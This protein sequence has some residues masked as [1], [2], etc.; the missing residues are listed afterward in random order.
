VPDMAGPRVYEMAEMVHTYL[1]ANGKHRLILPVRLPGQANSVFRAGA[2]LAPQ[3]A[4]GRRTWEDVLAGRATSPHESAL[5][6]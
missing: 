6:A 3:R 5:R 2:N 4:V 1:H